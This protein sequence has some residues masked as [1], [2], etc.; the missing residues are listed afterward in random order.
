M[1]NKLWEMAKLGDLVTFNPEALSNKTPGDTIIKYIDIAS[2]EK[3]GYIAN[4]RAL[5]FGEAPS[6]ARRIVREGDTI[7][8]TVRPYLKS[9]AYIG[10]KNHN[11]IC[12]TGFAVLRPKKEVSPHFIYQT[13][14]RDDFIEYLKT[15]MTGSN[16]PAVNA[17]DISEYEL[18][19][20]PIA[21]QH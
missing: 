10:S 18:T 9:F 1:V 5:K 20:P 3:T 15:K 14:L 8:S 13:V 7:L 19:I 11:N 2:V 4:P 21:E 16:Y 6:R 17:S 12:S